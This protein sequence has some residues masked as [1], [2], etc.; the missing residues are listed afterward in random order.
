MFNPFP[1][2]ALCRRGCTVPGEGWSPAE[3]EHSGETPRR[4]RSALRRRVRGASPLAAARIGA[5]AARGHVVGWWSDAGGAA[6]PVV[7]QRAPALAIGPLRLCSRPRCSDDTAYS[8]ADDDY[9]ATHDDNDTTPG[10]PRARFGSGDNDD[11]NARG[12]PYRR[13]F[14][15]TGGCGQRARAGHLVR[16]GGTGKVCEPD[17]PLRDGG[18]GDEWCHR[19]KYDLCG[20]RSRASRLPACA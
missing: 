5:R 16:G 9:H 6:C 3:T 15:T 19:S 7:V 13:R 8:S 17:A 14:A 11:D 1:S 4:R 2:P 18:D 10:G 20:R 12:C